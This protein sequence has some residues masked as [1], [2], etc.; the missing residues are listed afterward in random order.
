MTIDIEMFLHSVLI[1]DKAFI[2]LQNDSGMIIASKLKMSRN[3]YLR[4][5]GRILKPTTYELS[6]P[7]L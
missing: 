7:I 3:L 1:L 4:C 6:F 5:S 2:P